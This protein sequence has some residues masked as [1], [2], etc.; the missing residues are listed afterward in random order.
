MKVNTIKSHEVF[1]GV[2]SGI[3]TDCMAPGFEV[4]LNQSSTRLVRLAHTL[5]LIHI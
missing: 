3:R 2:P 1:K 5:S 4:W